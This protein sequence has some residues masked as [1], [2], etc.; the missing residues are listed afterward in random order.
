MR[1]KLTNE[2]EISIRL[3][4]EQLEYI[5]DGISVAL[6]VIDRKETLAADA[7]KDFT[8]RLIILDKTQSIL[9]DAFDKLGER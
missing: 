5:C 2:I 6:D 8:R 3:A 9:Y 4:K 7:L 1:T